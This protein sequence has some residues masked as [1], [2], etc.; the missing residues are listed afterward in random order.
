MEKKIKELEAIADLNQGLFKMEKYGDKDF[1]SVKLICSEAGFKSKV[2]EYSL[3]NALDKTIKKY[4][5]F[6]KK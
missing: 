4:K 1:W 6:I 5:E 3:M 2:Y